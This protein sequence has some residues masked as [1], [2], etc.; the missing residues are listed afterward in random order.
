M[1]VNTY[2]TDPAYIRSVLEQGQE[3]L[4][5]V[6]IDRNLRVN[7]KPQILNGVITCLAYAE[8]MTAEGMTTDEPAV[9]SLQGF[10]ESDEG[11]VG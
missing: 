9:F 1:D 2:K 4:F 6:N 3:P 7:I 5:I 10:V 8:F 11:V